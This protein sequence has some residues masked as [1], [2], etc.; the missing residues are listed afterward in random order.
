MGAHDF[1]MELEQG[2]ATPLQERGG[3]LSIGQRQLISFARAIVGDPQVLILDE[4]TANVDTNSEMQIQRALAD[5]LRDRTAVVIA[6]RLSTIRDADMIVVLEEG[7]IEERGTHDE[8]MALN[9][10]YARLQSLD[11]PEGERTLRPG[12]P[13]GQGPRRPGDPGRPGE[14]AGR[15]RMGDGGQGRGGR[16]PGGGP[17][18]GMRGEG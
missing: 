3:N 5:M 18:P 8:L 16:R 6:H 14:W 4:A 13:G 1:I 17:P 15:G 9:G 2:Y 7:R 10:V 12:G 11:G